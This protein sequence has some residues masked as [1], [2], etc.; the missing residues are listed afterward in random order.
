MRAK[1]ARWS[2]R[3]GKIPRDA[4]MTRRFAITTAPIM[5]ADD[6]QKRVGSRNEEW[7]PGAGPSRLSYPRTKY[8]TALTFFVELSSLVNLRPNYGTHVGKRRGRRFPMMKHRTIVAVA[9]IT[10][11]QL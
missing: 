2:N 3:N 11:P 1:V 8:A 10:E 7:L 6:R 4:R 5:P 9:L